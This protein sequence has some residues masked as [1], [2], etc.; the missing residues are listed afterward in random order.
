MLKKFDNALYENNYYL[1]L[2]NVQRENQLRK[3]S[4]RKWQQEDLVQ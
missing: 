4:K 1:L 2:N 3:E